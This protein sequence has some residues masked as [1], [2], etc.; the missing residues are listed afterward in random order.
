MHF[1][2]ADFRVVEVDLAHDRLELHWRDAQGQPLASIDGLRHWG[3]GQG[4]ELL[5]ATNAGIYDR[6]FRPLG[7]YVEEGVALRPLNT[8]RGSAGAGN[9]SIQPNGVFYVDAR[10]HAGVVA[11]SDWRER[12]IEARLATQSGPMLVVDGAINPAFDEQ[13]DSLKWRSGVC[14]RAPQQVVFAV[15]EAP[16]TFHAFAR[17]FRD[18]LGCRDAL[19]LDGTLSRIY[20]KADGYTGAAAVMVKPYA[21]MFAVFV[22]RRATE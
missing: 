8:A 10:N 16:V 6:Q 3:D 12:R 11:T 20:T 1:D 19:Y 7:L 14:A 9:F 17:L 22:D 5:F 2:A 13:S 4:R 18:E 21:G 15:S